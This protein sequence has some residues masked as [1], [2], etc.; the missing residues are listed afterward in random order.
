[1]KTVGIS[2]FIQNQM[3]KNGKSELINISIEEVAQYAE[4]HLNKGNFKPGYRDGV[5]RIE[6]KEK[7]F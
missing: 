4:K 2:D 3:K 5:I 7:T 1:M 6:S